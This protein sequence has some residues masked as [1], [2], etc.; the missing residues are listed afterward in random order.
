MAS[1]TTIFDL[2]VEILDIVL[3]HLDY[4][5]IAAFRQTCPPAAAMV[6]LAKI[7][8]LRQGIRASLLEEEHADHQRRQEAFTNQRRWAVVFPQSVQGDAANTT[9]DSNNIHRNRITRAERLNCYACLKHLPRECF[10]KGQVTGSRSLGHRDGHRR[11]CKACGVKKRIWEKGAII[12]DGGCTLVVCKV[13]NLLRRVDAEGK[14]VGIC[15]VCLAASQ[16][17]PLD[18][19][20]QFTSHPSPSQLASRATRCQRCWAIDHTAVPARSTES[21]ICPSC[22]AA[23]RAGKDGA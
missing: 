13:C 18:T 9:N 4:E 14:K 19:E 5:S 11:F 16:E 12:K 21:R 20:R 3:T 10:V 2:H 1:K 8:R 7:M 6:P 15:S 22:E 23:C 17:T